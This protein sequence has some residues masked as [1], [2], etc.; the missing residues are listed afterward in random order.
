MTG[1]DKEKYEADYE[2][3]SRRSK[4]YRH[5]F[6]P[7]LGFIRGKDSKG[8]FR[9]EYS[10][11]SST[12]RAD[13]YCEGTAW[14]WTWFVPHDVDGLVAL[15]GSKENFAN[16]LDALFT[17]PSGLT[18]D[19]VSPDVSGFIGQYA[20]GNEPGHHT[21]HLYNYVGRPWRT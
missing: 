18:G 12:H 6:D 8:N 11:F 14:Q 2:Y 13:D 4:S 5:L 1:E 10:P 20:H 19:D 3:F 7:E 9:K 21:T 15:M 16:K 17:A